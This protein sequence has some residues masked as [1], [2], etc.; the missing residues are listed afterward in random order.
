MKEA[1]DEIQKVYQRKTMKEEKE[2]TEQ[3]WV[4]DTIRYE[5]KEK[6]TE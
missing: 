5:T 4:N 3:S 6:D 2:I 1:A